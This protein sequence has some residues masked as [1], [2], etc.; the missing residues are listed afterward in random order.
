M[1]TFNRDTTKPAHTFPEL[2]HL[3]PVKRAKLFSS[4]T[5]VLNSFRD[6]LHENPDDNFAGGTALLFVDLV[7]TLL[8][9]AATVEEYLDKYKAAFCVLLDEGDVLIEKDGK[10]YFICPIC[11]MQSEF[12]PDDDECVLQ[13]CK[14]GIADCCPNCSHETRPI[15][16]AFD[17][18]R[19]NLLNSDDE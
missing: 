16:E 8:D 5:V 14:N 3:G 15:R 4:I 12:D 9:G 19:K 13:I 6:Y 7:R 2:P 10:G 17:E 1:Y 18:I 11:H